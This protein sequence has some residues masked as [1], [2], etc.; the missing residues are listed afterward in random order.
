MRGVVIC[1][2]ITGVTTP[3]GGLAAKI[4]GANRRARRLL[5][6]Q[7]MIRRPI[8]QEDEPHAQ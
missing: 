2:R 7:A 8:R 1:L 6:E 4:R 3:G 5:R